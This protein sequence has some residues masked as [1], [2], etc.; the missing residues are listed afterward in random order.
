MIKA[1]GL[2]VQSAE[3]KPRRLIINTKMILGA[4][5]TA[6]FIAYLEVAYLSVINDK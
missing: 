6:R 2:P 4:V 3:R 5:M 1:N